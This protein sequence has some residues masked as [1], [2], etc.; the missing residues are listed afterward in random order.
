MAWQSPKTDWAAPD[1]VRD[2]D[3]NRIEGNILHL[4]ETGAARDNITIYVSPPASSVGGGS[5][6]DENG[7]GSSSSPFATVTKAL[8]VLPKHLN[9]MNVSI[10]I[11]E[12]TYADDVDIRGFSGGML[13]LTGALGATVSLRSLT[14]SSCNVTI[15]AINLTTTGASGITVTNGANLMSFSDILCSSSGFKVSNCSTAAISGRL[16]IRGA[17]TAIDVFANS[18]LHA[19]TIT[20]TNNTIGL[21]ASGG[22]RI[23]YSISDLVATTAAYTSSG[24]R[25]L[26]GAQ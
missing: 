16:T 23:S 21:S 15:S 9:G 6:N 14:I 7:T 4:Y 22:S 11:A 8:S 1:G 10:Y 19:S 2:R 24:G 17:Y 5:G 12:G 3:F 20:G 26:T 25:I 13:T 18:S